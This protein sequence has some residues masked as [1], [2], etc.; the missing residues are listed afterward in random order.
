MAV[1]G[2]PA[3]VEQV[4][5]CNGSFRSRLE[6]VQFLYFGGGGFEKPR[7]LKSTLQLITDAGGGWPRGALA[8]PALKLAPPEH[9]IMLFHASGRVSRCL[10]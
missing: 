7:G 1:C 9:G 2:E 6:F 4:L 8:P 10:L 5:N 3:D